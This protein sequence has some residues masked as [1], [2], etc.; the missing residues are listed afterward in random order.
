MNYWLIGIGIAIGAALGGLLFFS[1]GE[2]VKLISNPLE[3]RPGFWLTPEELSLPYENV[4][5]TTDDGLELQG[6]FIAPQ[7]GAVV[8]L[9]HG[10]KA[11]RSEVLEEAEMLYRHGFG[12]LI[13]SIRSHDV[14]PGVRITFGQKEIQDIR[15]WYDYLLTREGVSADK[16]GA[17]GLSMG[18][19]ILLKFASQNDE[20]QA[21]MAQSAFSS[22]AETVN[23]SVQ[24]F[25]NLPP[26]PFATLI[27]FWA[28]RE[29][30]FPLSEVNAKEWIAKISPRAVLILQGG[31]DDAISKQSGERLFEA[32]HEPKEFWF[33]ADGEHANF[34]LLF[35]EEFEARMI[36]FFEQYL[37]SDK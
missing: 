25:A 37:L 12:S 22:L 35:P 31:S 2:A 26:F 8:M 28:E 15:A 4:T 18:A 9:Q 19:A 32:A 13:T 24:A 33:E 16:I 14:N 17:Y 21:V 34:D 10:Y 36:E 23:Q 6:W 7:N 11:N 27:V 29:L 3:A 30:G 1:H 5:V 20:L